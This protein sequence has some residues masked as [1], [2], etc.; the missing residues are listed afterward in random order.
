MTKIKSEVIDFLKTSFVSQA[1]LAKEAG[2]NPCVLN[3]L[4]LGKSK[5]VMS[6]TADKL[7]VAMKM[8]KERQRG[9][10]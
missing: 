3:F 1:H 5:D 9:T 7:R 8:I 10:V 4:V 6:E 2:V